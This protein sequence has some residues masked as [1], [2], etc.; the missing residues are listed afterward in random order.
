MTGSGTFAAEAALIALRRAPGKDREFAFMSWPRYRHGLWR[1]LRMEAERE[2]LA[3]LSSEILAADNNPRAV[4][5][6]RLNFDTL[7]LGELIQLCQIDMQ[8]LEP[9]SSSGL[10][11]CNPP[12]GERLGKNAALS[13]FYRDIGSCY[14]LTFSTWK[15]ALLCPETQ[16]LKASGINL[17]PLLHFSNGGIKVVLWQ[18]CNREKPIKS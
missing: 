7:G 4:A 17:R 8:K 11:I 9:S 3:E 5:A 18:K 1:Q 6:A 12:Y 14:E 16:Q 2:E 13:A 10:L 15:G